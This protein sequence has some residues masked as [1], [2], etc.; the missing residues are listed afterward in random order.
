MGDFPLWGRLLVNGIIFVGLFGWFPIVVL[1][2][3]CRRG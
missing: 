3:G 2:G 1:I